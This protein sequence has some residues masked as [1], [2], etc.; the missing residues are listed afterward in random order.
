MN[1]LGWTDFHVVGHSMCG[2]AMQ[3]MILDIDDPKRVKSVVGIDPV[4][5]CGGQLD[6]QGWALF[7]GAIKRDDNRYR[8]LDFT[9]GNRNTPRWIEYMVERSHATTT[10]NAYA[11]YLNA[12]AT[13]TFVEEAKGIDTP[14][15]VCIGEH[16]LAFTKEAMEST[17]LTWLPNA[18]L[19]IIENAGHY[20][21]QEAPVNLVTVMEGFL[22]RH[23]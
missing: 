4:P 11:G 10:E 20:P 8:I 14:V 3:R 5:A 6:E 9:T 1:E 15:L 23:S 7:E 16:D 12:W 2:M 13:E 17:F 18:E 19:E 21:M 22:A